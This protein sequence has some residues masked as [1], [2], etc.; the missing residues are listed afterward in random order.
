MA[1]ADS[2]IDENPAFKRL[3]TKARS[4]EWVQPVVRDAYRS[5]RYGETPVDWNQATRIAAIWDAVVGD[6]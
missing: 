5:K 4:I 1:E 6:D 2:V 3:Y